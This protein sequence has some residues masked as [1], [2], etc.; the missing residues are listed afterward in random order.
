MCA[1]ADLVVRM[2]ALQQSDARR[3][4]E[5]VASYNLPNAI[6]EALNVQDMINAMEV[7]KKV[8]AGKLRFIIP[9][10]IGTVKI[11][12]DVDREMIKEVINSIRS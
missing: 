1:A 12:D 10:S 4:K 5:L 3:I 7:D 2:K 6:P 11:E 9:E 8:K